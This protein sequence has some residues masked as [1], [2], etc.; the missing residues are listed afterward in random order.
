M[1]SRDSREALYELVRGIEPSDINELKHRA[2]KWQTAAGT[3]DAVRDRMGQHTEDVKAA[4]GPDSEVAQAASAS[5][6]TSKT[7][8][9]Q[10][11]T[12]L[13]TSATHLSNIAD[14]LHPAVADANK[15]AGDDQ[16]SVESTGAPA[17]PT[18]A[19]SAKATSHVN[20]INK[21]Y[22]QAIKHFK[23]IDSLPGQQPVTPPSGGS[24]AGGAPGGG[25]PTNVPTTT[26][27]HPSTSPTVTPTAPPTEPTS[28]PT[29]T[30]P[31]HHSDPGTT[32]PGTTPTAPSGGG[33]LQG[34]GTPIPSGPTSAPTQV[35]A[36]PAASAAPPTQSGGYGGADV[37]G[38]GAGAMGGYGAAG[39]GAAL[40]FSP[41]QSLG[42]TPTARPGG[43]LLSTEEDA[44]LGRRTVVSAGGGSTS[45]GGVGAT[46]SGA[47]GR[48]A[49]GRGGRGTAGAS[50][51][52]ATAAGRGRARKR[53]ERGPDDLWDDGSDWIDDE[54]TGPS[55]MQ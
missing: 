43:A 27:K 40:R 23:S 45:T 7:Q 55:V 1:A 51:T 5:F 38:A 31:V 8:L 4:F 42:G 35:P 50:R 12:E 22:N 47:G 16:A 33:L 20:D 19:E 10:K 17:K 13:R 46:G 9:H 37:L 24:S 25:G 54:G 34:G 28:P 49:G 53:G 29:S 2:S 48:G 6:A 18:D 3:L 32:T 30:T 26:T 14:V 41:Q 36:A 44:A 21:A 15:W 11:A 39:G 52:G